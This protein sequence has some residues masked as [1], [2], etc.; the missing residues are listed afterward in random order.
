ML[1]QCKH[2]QDTYICDEC[3]TLCKKRGHSFSVPRFFF[4]FFFFPQNTLSAHKTAFAEQ[5]SNNKFPKTI[6]TTSVNSR[7]RRTWIANSCI[8]FA[9]Y[10]CGWFSDCSF[11]KRKSNNSI[12]VSLTL[13]LTTLLK[14]LWRDARSRQALS[15]QTKSNRASEPD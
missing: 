12:V 8:S 7:I 1:I 6:S 14:K 9:G 11:C 2:T 5:K 13:L 3:L 10:P 15:S 4:F